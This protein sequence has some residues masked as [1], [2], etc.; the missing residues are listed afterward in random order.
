[1]RVHAT[2]VN[3]TD[4]GLR[5]AGYFITRFFTGLLRPKR[6]IVGTELGAHRRGYG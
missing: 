6:T 2:T 3:R 1:M 5:T 4:C